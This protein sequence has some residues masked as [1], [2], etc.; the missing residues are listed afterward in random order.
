MPLEVPRRGRPVADLD[1]R[2][3]RQDDQHHQFDSQQRLLEV[4]GDLYAPV[5]DIG[6][7]D[8]PEHADKQDPAAARVLPDALGVE[9][10]EPVLPG[11]LG[12]A[13]HDQ[14]I[15]GD[16]PPAASPA[17][18]R[19]ERAGGPGERGAA[20]RVRLVQ[21]AVADRGEQHRHERQYRHGR[22]LQ[23]DRAD[24]EHQRRGDAVSRCDRGGRDD[25][26]RDQA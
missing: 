12:Q 3:D 14:D 18:P 5:T 10:Q 19:I 21:L 11:D 22:R 7:H 13:R 9:Q 6:H 8:D 1:Q 4:R 26:G 20:V 2:G 23:R 17:G 15:G 25:G 24:H 16:D